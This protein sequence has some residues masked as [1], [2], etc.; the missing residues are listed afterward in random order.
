MRHHIYIWKTLNRMNLEKR[1]KERMIV[2]V[3]KNIMTCSAWG[4]DHAY[5]MMMMMMMMTSA[6]V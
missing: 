4:I 3:F 2:V 5:M 1:K 6:F